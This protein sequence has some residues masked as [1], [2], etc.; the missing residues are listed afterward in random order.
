MKKNDWLLLASVLLYSYLFYEQFA[1]INFLIFNLALVV[2]LLLRNPG[3]LKDR[4]WMVAVAGALISS[5]CIMYY[6]SPLAIIANVIALMLLSF[7]SIAPRSS[8]FLSLFMSGLSIS[9]SVVFMFIDWVRRNKDR[10]QEKS[11]PLYVVIIMFFF[12]SIITILFFL[13]YQSSNP[14]FK[15]FTKNINLDF[16]SFPWMFFTLGGLLLLYGFYYPRRIGYFIELDENASNV[17]IED[18]TKKSNFLNRLFKLE[19]EYLTGSILFVILNLMLLLLNILDLNYLWFD[20]KL[21]EDVDY[22]EFVHDGIGMLITSIIFAIIII[23]FYFRGRLNFDPKTK[24][25]RWLACFWIFQNAFMIFSSAYRTN[26]YI[27]DYGISY[28]K[29]GVYVY[30][31]LT[32]IGLITTF[33]KVTKLKSNWYLVRV[34]TWCY[35]VILMI[36]CVFN[37]DVIITDFNIRKALNENKKLEKYYL[38]DLSFKNLPQLLQLNDTI[39]SSD[40]FGVRDYYYSSRGTYFYDF[41]SGL[42]SKLFRFMKDMHKADWRSWCSEKSRV[43]KELIRL[44]AEGKI[45]SID[46]S[47]YG[48]LSSLES[49]KDLNGIEDLNLQQNNLKNVEELSFFPKLKKLNLSFNSLDSINKF[50]EL[51]QLQVLDLGHNIITNLE[52]LK[53]ASELLDLKLSAM[54]LIQIEDLPEFKKLQTLDLSENSIN[55]FSPLGNYPDL[56]TLNIENTFRGN[57]IAFPEMK[58]LSSLDM[59]DNVISQNNAGEIFKKIG[60]SRNISSINVSRC[61]LGN[62]HELL[63]NTSNRSEQDSSRF[64][65]PTLRSLDLSNNVLYTLI[66]IGNYKGLKQLDVSNNKIRSVTEVFSLT[67]LQSLSIRGNNIDNIEGV[68]NLKDLITFDLS[69]CYVGKGIAFI[70]KLGSLQNLNASNNNIKSIEV[71]KNM[72]KLKSLNLSNNLIKNIAG[73]ENLKELEELNLSGM[74]MADYSPLYGLKNLK[75]LYVASMPRQQLLKLKKA[76]PNCTVY[77]YEP[78][79]QN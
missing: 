20:G 1:G 4:S 59:S 34:N 63:Y 76:L 60:A 46:L 53:S 30:L 24:Y 61:N 28:K 17:L 7:L 74:T 3:S 52:P 72:T 42:D 18:Q 9:S 2:F 66:G 10:S 39:K 47:R 64:N 55:N 69:A 51:K 68:E 70:A 57:L 12:I 40:D 6:T 13:M 31:G 44:N 16:I 75:T 32:L 38:A 67:D 65:F 43:Y 11:R 29:I 58:K 73:M 62:I 5:T 50:P 48:V 15:E 33:I 21:P 23:L 78:A 37:W 54:G 45:K 41:R 26:M 35:F 56:T 49:I 8:V 71:F 79:Y 25:L 36:S 14:A 19:T 77:D 27:A 22:K